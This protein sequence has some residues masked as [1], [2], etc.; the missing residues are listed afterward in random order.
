IWANISSQLQETPELML[1]GYAETQADALSFI[2]GRIRQLLTSLQLNYGVVDAALGSTQDDILQIIEIA[3]V[4][5]AES[6]LETFKSTIETIQRA[7]NLA[8]KASDETSI[9][10]DK[11]ETASEKNLYDAVLSV[12]E[13]YADF[14]VRERYAA[15][16]NLAPSIHE[17]FEENMVM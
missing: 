14:S 10:T 5:E 11:F 13:R 1:S 2:K 9:E 12:K 7:I 16:S 3:Q 17:F 8:E 6:Q 4:L 15:L